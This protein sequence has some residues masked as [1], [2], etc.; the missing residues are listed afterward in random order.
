MSH[1]AWIATIALILGHTTTSSAQLFKYLDKYDPKE[2][3][4]FEKTLDK[5]ACSVISRTEIYGGEKSKYTVRT[6][7]VRSFDGTRSKIAI[8]EIHHGH[9]LSIAGPDSTMIIE[10]ISGVTEIHLLRPELLEVLYSPR[11]GSDQGFEYAIILGIKNNHLCIA[12][13]F[14]T[15]NEYTIPDEYHLHQ[16]RL[17]FLGQTLRDCQLTANVRNVLKA[18]IHKSKNYDRKNLYVLRF[19]RTRKIFY[20]KVEHLNASDTSAARP[21]LPTGDYPIID[22]GPDAKYYYVDG[23]WYGL[24]KDDSEHK[25]VLSNLH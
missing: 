12:A 14:L 3:L 5:D 18:D 17:K 2:A 19:D 1:P 6:Y 23:A 4:A 8:S 16:V 15:I 25:W 24:I 10:D 9:V 7:C 13:E 20:S 22:L 21:S 11:G